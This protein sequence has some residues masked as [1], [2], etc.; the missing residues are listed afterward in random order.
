MGLGEDEIGS[1]EWPIFSVE[2]TGDGE[3]GS[4]P[5]VVSISEALVGAGVREH[6]P[7]AGIR[8]HSR[9]SA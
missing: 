2:L 5:S 8:R 4:V 1:E 9:A 6:P 3:G 7:T